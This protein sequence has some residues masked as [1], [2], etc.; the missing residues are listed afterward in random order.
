VVNSAT[1]VDNETIVLNGT[2]LVSGN[3]TL[4]LDNVTLRVNSTSAATR[5]IQVSSPASLTVLNSV[6]TTQNTAYRFY[7][8][9]Y[10]TLRVEGS[11]VSHLS[12]YGIYSRT[13]NLVL[14][15]NQIHD[16]SYSGVYVYLTESQPT[17][18]L[19]GNTLYDLDYY[20]MVLYYYSYFSASGGFHQLAGDF[21]VRNNTV[22]DNVGGGIYVYRYLYDYLNAGSSLRANLTVEGNQFLR[23]RGY[24]LFVYNYI[25]NSQGGSG[26]HSAFDGRI[27]VNDNRFEEN[28]AYYAVY[29]RNLVTMS[30][31]G[32]TTIDVDVF[33]NRNTIVN[34]SGSGVYLD[35]VS[36]VDHSSAGDVVNNGEMW[37]LDNVVTGNQGYGIY[38][39]R[40]SYALLARS[41]L[42]NGRITLINNTIVGNL[43]TGMYVFNYAY[44]VD[45]LSASIDGPVRIERNTA[46]SNSGYGIYTYNYAWKFQ[47]NQNG[48]A[49]IRGDLAMK[50][51]AV[52]G[53]LAGP[54]IFVYRNANSNTGSTAYIGGDIDLSFNHVH[55][56]SGNG[57][58][59]VFQSSKNLGRASGVCV[60]DSNLTLEGNWVANNSLYVGISVERTAY[61][62]YSSASR[63]TG[64]TRI[65]GNLIEG[66]D[67]NGLYLEQ[68]SLNYYGA[69][70][71]ESIVEGD[72][73]F[74]DNTIRDNRLA[75]AYLYFYSYSYYSTSSR[76]VSNF[77][78]V[79]NS[80]TDNQAVGLFAYFYAYSA[81][82]VTG[83]TSCVNH[84]V[85]RDNRF[86]RNKGIGFQL[87][88]IAAGANTAGNTVE[89]VGDLAIEGNVAEGNL[90]EGMYLYNSA[91]NTNGDTGARSVMAGDWTV[92]DNELN[93]NLGTYGGMALFSSIGASD[94]E[95][96][97]QQ[98]DALVENN[99]VRSNSGFGM[100]LAWG[101][102]QSYFKSA[103]DRGFFNQTG[104][105]VVRGNRFDSNALYG[106]YASYSV[107]AYVVSSTAAPDISNNSVSGNHGYY[108]LLLNMITVQHG[109]TVRDNEVSSNEGAG[110]VQIS[111][112]GRATELLFA[113]NSL[114]QN[115]ETL[116]GVRVSV[117]G[118]EYDLTV[119]GNTALDND[120]QGPLFQI[121]NDGR[122]VVRRNLVR[123]NVNTTAAFQVDAPGSGASLDFHNNT[124]T[125][126]AG[127]GLL[128]V[129][130]G[131]VRVEDNVVSSNGGDGLSVRTLGD[132]LTS[133]ADIRVTRNTVNQ[134]GGNGLFSYATHWLAVT[135]NNATGNQLAGLRV[136]F[137]AVDPLVARNNLDGN[138]FGV[139]LSG[140]GTSALTSSHPVSNLTVRNSLLAGL[141]VEDAAV[142]LWNSTV[143][144]P[145]GVDLSVRQG[146]IDAYGSGVGFLRGEVRA[147]GE[148][149]VWWNLSFRV[150][151]QNGA[152]VPGALV[153]M[154]G[155]TGEPYGQKTANATGRVAPFRAAEWSMVDASV[156]PWS[157]YTFTGVKNG[158]EG[159]NTTALDRDKEVWIVIRDVHAPALAVAFP[160]EGGL[161]NFSVVPWRGNVSDVGSGL[162]LLEVSV[163]G[164]VRVSDT[165]P[166]SPFSGSPAALADGNHTYRFRA[167]DAAGVATV[168]TVNFTVDTTPPVLVVLE[169]LRT[170]V[171]TSLVTVRV[172]TSPD[173]VFA[174]IMYDQV[175][176]GPGAVFESV[177]RVHEGPN[178][179]RLRA[180]DRAGNANETML[181]ITLDTTP[182][183]LSVEE[184]EDGSFTNVPIVRV[185][186]QSEPGATVL[187]G[188]QAADVTPGGAFE[189]AAEL[190]E[191]LNLVAVAAQDEAGNWA[192]LAVR[193][194]LDQT[195][196]ALT[197]TSPVDGLVTREDFVSVEG[198]AEDGAQVFVNGKGGQPL[199]QFLETVHLEEGENVVVVVAR[200]RAGNTAREERRVVK[201]TTIPFIEVLEPSG[202]H[203]FTNDSTYTIRG[204]TEPSARVAGAGASAKAD[205]DGVF[206]LRVNL[207]QAET[208]VLI[209]VWDLVENRNSTAVTITH[210]TAPPTLVLF[211][212]ANGSTYQVGAAEVIGSTD[213]GALLTVNGAPVQVAVDGT[214]RWVVPLEEGTNFV[215][216]RAQDKAGNTAEARLTLFLGSPA[217]SGEPP[218]A[219]PGALNGTRTPTQPAGAGGDLMLLVGLIAVGGLA[220]VALW[221]RGKLQRHGPSLEDEFERGGR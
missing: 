109:I 45:G 196:P 178:L 140:N 41:A 194:T 100:Y 10:G 182:P 188:G 206:A 133:T 83:D 65:R 152:P 73:D 187:V 146:R 135:D 34:N 157:P 13:G 150:V 125:L 84:V 86:L 164:A 113:N 123:G 15:N 117:T 119:E 79:N 44:A 31:S 46:S 30:F 171:N 216:I 17:V 201:D 183:A 195:P 81:T 159:S 6:L 102:S 111:N 161:Y 145:S 122:T 217:G 107:S 212:P 4:R 76:V 49:E 14:R 70:G 56:N 197:V 172:Q 69:A 160:V 42:V 23:N 7:F 211:A 89:L 153:L 80:I 88:R 96:A 112:G 2:L 55:N 134:N 141:M 11:D 166:A 169:P 82:A 59:V 99:T 121:G 85:A 36:T 130:E 28:S 136:N 192:Y 137:L 61:A 214:F 92:R 132:W 91:S 207:S 53:N 147:S 129:S 218:T 12:T 62:T 64:W 98:T 74:T 35:F 200:D 1:S 144:S 24:G 39:Y 220:A 26:A 97:Y 18:I 3:I 205:L 25:W 191:G 184:P 87:Y 209:E 162:A 120:I 38:V 48:T 66:H 16:G 108:A 210:D 170:L 198:E 208:V 51:N 199:G 176:V 154:N 20:A 63:V 90:G 175:A 213:F 165:A 116:F 173:A 95:M 57:I 104:N 189:G 106:L 40:Y 50:W 5:G 58:G 190:A 163:D 21:I 29:L 186:G 32:G 174:L 180:V 110:A 8:Y 168:L 124:I 68:N 204:R 114:R 219:P 93:Q 215:V 149:H 118:G 127:A 177:V 52:H 22:R 167:V 151:W 94:V 43:D 156:F 47:G 67:L 60:I 185:V 143:L 131:V 139:V 9:N 128:A 71:A 138:R 203:G 75:A 78:A 179:V 103:A 126:S 221:T 115:R 101:G 37:F 33:F 72:V 54:A 181:A 148:I 158:E 155:S 202:G 27:T 142:A 105:M 193:V 19:E 77:T